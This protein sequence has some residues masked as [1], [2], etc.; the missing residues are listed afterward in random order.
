MTSSMNCASF[1]E[2]LPGLP[3]VA[4]SLGVAACAAGA[5]PAQPAPAQP[6][7]GAVTAP[8]AEPVT[9]P[10]S[11]PVAEAPPA[12]VTQPADPLPGQIVWE[13]RDS[14]VAVPDG[15]RTCSA[16]EDCELVIAMCCDQC[17]DGKAVSV[18]K[19]HVADARAKFQ[20]TGCGA[21]TKRGCSTRAFCDRGR[22][23]LQWQSVR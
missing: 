4:L 8:A 18:G 15:W 21:C 17:N 6:S 13:T 11:A 3:A 19:T 20:R 22:C 16:P 7:P 5:A 23:V 1:R 10:P 14:G 12:P 2:L 9:T